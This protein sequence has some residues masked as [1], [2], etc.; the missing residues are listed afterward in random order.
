MRLEFCEL[1]EKEFAGVKF[2]CGSFYR[3]WRC[4]DGIGIWDEKR[5]WWG[6][7]EGSKIVAAGLILAQNGILGR[8]LCGCQG[9][10]AG[11]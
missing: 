1:E 5:I 8:K 10:V 6:V 7:R 11:L 9:M 4:I 2:A 3:A